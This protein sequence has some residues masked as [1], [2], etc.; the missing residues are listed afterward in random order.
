MDI[1]NKIAVRDGQ[2][3]PKKLR[4]VK[5]YFVCV[6]SYA[7]SHTK[8]AYSH[9]QAQKVCSRAK[10]LGLDAYVSSPILRNERV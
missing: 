8:R 1:F 2:L 4:T 3:S 5:L 9:R 7:N 6:G 10:R